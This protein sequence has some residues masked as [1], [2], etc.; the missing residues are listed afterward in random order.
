MNATR[1][2]CF[3]VQLRCRL[4]QKRHTHRA[5]TGEN[6]RARLCESAQ[7]GAGRELGVENGGYTVHEGAE[8]HPARPA[9]E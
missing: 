5:D 9:V 7:R 1:K 6:C 8:E 2:L 3:A 4:R